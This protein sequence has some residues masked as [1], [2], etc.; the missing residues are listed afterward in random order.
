MDTEDNLDA[1]CNLLDDDDDS[2]DEAICNLV[3][4]EISKLQT[5]DDDTS[6]VNSTDK[7]PVPE[8]PVS[9]M[10]EKLRKMQ[11]EMQKMQEQLAVAKSSQQHKNIEEIDVFQ[12]S[13]SRSVNNAPQSPVKTNPFAEADKPRKLAQFHPETPIFGPSLAKKSTRV[14][15]KQEAIDLDFKL[16]KGASEREMATIAAHDLADSSDEDMVSF[17]NQGILIELFFYSFNIK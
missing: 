9:A 7:P 15:S 1:L 14:L 3:D 12:A 13:T 2:F 6:I 17:L 5:V 11:E 4:D 16:K 8:N 10:E